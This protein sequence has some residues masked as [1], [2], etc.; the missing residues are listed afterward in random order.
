MGASDPATHCAAGVAC[1]GAALVG[2]LPADALDLFEEV[3]PRDVGE[4]FAAEGPVDGVVEGAVGEP[5]GKVTQEALADVIVGEAGC[6][7]Q[8]ISLAAATTSSSSTRS[9]PWA[10]AV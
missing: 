2:A 3:E 9:L 8:A 7:H 10:A 6:G 1:R 5:F 4:E